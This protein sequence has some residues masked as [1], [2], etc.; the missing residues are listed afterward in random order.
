M[1]VVIEYDD[2]SLGL[3]PGITVVG[4]GVNCDLRF[5]DRSVSRRHARLVVKE[6]TVLLEDLGT[7]NG[8][9]LNDERIAGTRILKDGDRVAIGRRVVTVK[10]L[11]GDF[12]PDEFEDTTAEHG[13]LIADMARRRKRDEVGALLV[14]RDFKLGE[15]AAP[16]VTHQNCPRCRA[17]LALDA[18]SC[19]SCGTELGARTMAK[20]LELTKDMIERRG[21][22]R[23]LVNV[24][25]LYTSDNVTFEAQAHDLSEEGIFVASELIDPVG[26]PC[27]VTLLEDGQPPRTAVGV[28]S[29]VFEEGQ[30]PGGLPRGMGIRFSKLRG[31]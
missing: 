26:T 20:T 12:S 28:V 23:R 31:K 25:C 24:P 18:S 13:V 17:S 22:P 19:G 15:T 29:H 7:T 1:R 14:I 10:I 21:Q 6:D 2:H 8:T 3:A 30:A 9:L 11:P 27:A 4:R 16:K 5:N